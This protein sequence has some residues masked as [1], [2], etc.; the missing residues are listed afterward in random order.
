MQKIIFEKDKEDLFIGLLDGKY[1]GV[2]FKK[3]IEN[4][5]ELRS[6]EYS[7]CDFEY[8]FLTLMICNFER[9]I[10]MSPET[11]QLWIK[12][13]DRIY[14]DKFH[15]IKTDENGKN[16]R[17]IQ[18]KF[19]KEISAALAYSKLQ[20]KVLKKFFHSVKN[21]KT[22][23]YCNSQY[24][25]TFLKDNN[26]AVKFQIDHIFPKKKYPYFSISMYNLIPSCASCN[27]NKGDKDFWI[28]DY[29]N[30]Y[31]ES[32][33]DRFKFTI[34]KESDKTLYNSVNEVDLEDI[35][36]TISNL[37]DKKVKAHNELFD[38]EGIHSNFNE[39]TKEI[40]A[41]GREYPENKR[42]ELLKKYKDKAGNLMFK[43]KETID[44]VF[45][46]VYPE[47]SKINNRPL[48]K[49]IQDIARFSDFY[50]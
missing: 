36:I 38:I 6:R 39:I 31:I 23:Y 25:L 27:L 11:I 13:I 42:N 1:S 50:D 17:L 10:K 49:F 18:T 46:R 21:I 8:A 28:E 3:P 33:G 44:R 15:Q 30:P 41:L 5:K 16:P 9:L 20:N 45:L 2:N 48:S 14:K 47:A 37:N 24:T 7:F 26:E 35:S 29:C 12:K 40:L 19:G 32:V 22:C 34:A 4:L 43:D